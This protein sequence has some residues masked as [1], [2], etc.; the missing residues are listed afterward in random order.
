[1]S[2]D[3]SVR[4]EPLFVWSPPRTRTDADLAVELGESM[5]LRGEPVVLTVHQ[6]AHLEDIFAEGSEPGIPAAFATVLIG[7]RQFLGKTLTL[8]V[9][10]LA[11][12][13]VFEVWRHIWTAHLVPTAKDAFVDMTSMI[14][15]NPEIKSL[16]RWPPNTANGQQAIQL[17]SGARLEFHA[18]SGGAGRG[19]T[20][21]RNT[22]DEGLYLTDEMV[23]DMLPTLAT[24]PHA[25]VRIAS[26]A[27]KGFSAVLRGFRDRGYA[28]SD[29]RLALTEFGVPFTP[30]EFDGCEH[31]KADPGCALND[32]DLW[33]RW[34]PLDRYGVED[35][36]ERI[37]V[38]RENMSPREFA[39]EFYSWADDPD[40]AEHPVNA[41]R[42]SALGIDKASPDAKQPPSAV[43]ISVEC[44]LEK[45]IT[46]VGVA[47]RRPDGKAQV[48]LAKRA[49]GTTWVIEWIR[50][51]RI[52]AH[53]PVAVVVD[54]AGPAGFLVAKLR[55]AGVDVLEPTA[56]QVSQACS[57]L[58][59][60]VNEGVIRDPDT[61]RE[62]P[63]RLVHT[64]DAVLTAAVHTAVAKPNGAFDRT[65]EKADQSPLYAATLALHG[66][67]N[68]PK[69]RSG[70]VW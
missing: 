18:R 51:E 9:A 45:S 31:G 52:E 8:I 66:L 4:C 59:A 16:C 41:E 44:N 46:T 19:K 33:R 3:T 65:V 49:H 34:I 69:K 11:D 10:A 2:V 70:N 63:S 13:F 38:F 56:R 5:A 68:R 21:D 22:L 47:A 37:A 64:R 48:E 23:G 27:G 1:M 53:R 6:V 35:G 42:W 62:T 32:R 26:S 58:V 43:A 20:G 30:C 39:R 24:I 55:A 40:D 28:G 14:A 17:H 36:L 60:T 61:R 67:L 50:R 15:S 29:R 12:M 57:D 25:Q 54:P 7:Q